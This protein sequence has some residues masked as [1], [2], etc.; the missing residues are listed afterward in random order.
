MDFLNHREGGMV[1]YKFFLL[2]PLQ[3][4]YSN[5]TETARGCVSL[6]KYKYKGKAVEVTVYTVTRKKTFKIFFRPRIRPLIPRIFPL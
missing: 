3:C 5:F 2:S 1:F 6:K 4:M